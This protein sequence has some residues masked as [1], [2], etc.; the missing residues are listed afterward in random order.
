MAEIGPTQTPPSQIAREHGLSDQSL[1]RLRTQADP[2]RPDDRRGGSVEDAIEAFVVER[3]GSRRELFPKIACVYR[4]AVCLGGL[5]VAP[6][7]NEREVILPID[8]CYG[9][10]A[11]VAA[12]PSTV[13]GKLFDERGAVLPLWRD[14]VD[15]GD[16][17]H[18]RP[19]LHCIDRPNGKREMDPRISGCVLDGSD[20]L[21]EPE[22]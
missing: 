10:E 11:K 15:V 7:F 18:C 14:D 3:T 16:D 5:T 22:R 6:H 17:C 12:I 2:T 13:L 9:L 4:D 20:L 8:L 1:S 19:A 21:M